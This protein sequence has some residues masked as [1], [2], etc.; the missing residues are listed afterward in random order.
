MC[1]DR[2]PHARL[3]RP[4]RVVNSVT[5]NDASHT[6]KTLGCESSEWAMV[7]LHTQTV[8][9]IEIKNKSKQVMPLCRATQKPAIGNY[10]SQGPAVAEKPTRRAA[11]RR[12]WQTDGRTNTR[13]QLIPA[14]A[15]VARIKWCYY[16]LVCI[17]SP[18]AESIFKLISPSDSA[19]FFLPTRRY[20]ARVLAVVVCLSV[21][22]SVCHKSVFYWNS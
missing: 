16:T 19:V 13:R 18:N 21:R 20:L 4:R 8:I 6:A 22:M 17:T 3:Y 15:S 11:S 10:K 2:R 14:L 9:S 12:M 1:S 5:R 7:P